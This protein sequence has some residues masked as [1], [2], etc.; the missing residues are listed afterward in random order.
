VVNHPRRVVVLKRPLPARAPAGAVYV[1]RRAWGLPGSP[2]GN[3]WVV[4]KDV[5]T[6][7]E[8]VERFR[9]KCLAEP[10]YVAA[11]AAYIGTGNAACWCSLGE[12][13]HGDVLLEFVDALA[14]GYDFEDGPT[15]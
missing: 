9:L 1:G 12:P 15:A 5:D 3:P 4:G 13:C 8:A 11:A 10:D 14:E 6:A 7:T 2:F